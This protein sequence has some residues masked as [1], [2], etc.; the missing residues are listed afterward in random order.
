MAE[1]TVDHYFCVLE[2][3]QEGQKVWRDKDG[4]PHRMDGPVIDIT[5]HHAVSWKRNS[6]AI[7]EGVS[8]TQKGGYFHG[9]LNSIGGPCRYHGIAQ[10]YNEWRVNGVLY[11]NGDKIG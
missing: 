7:I 10:Y 3:S 6:W 8:G 9:K 11:W 2:E 4:L 1:E 5:G